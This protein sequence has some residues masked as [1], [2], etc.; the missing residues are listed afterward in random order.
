[1]LCGPT[2]VSVPL[3]NDK[4]SIYLAQIRDEISFTSAYPE[5]RIYLYGL[6]KRNF[7]CE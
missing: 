4:G 3:H 5:S 6:Q 1:M 2:F 7:K